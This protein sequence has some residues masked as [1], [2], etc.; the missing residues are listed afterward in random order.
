VVYHP[1]SLVIVQTME[2]HEC[3]ADLLHRLRKVRDVHQAQLEQRRQT[4]DR[5]YVAVYELAQGVP[6]A[7][8][9]A[10]LR[11]LIPELREEDREGPQPTYVEAFGRAILVCHA[12]G[13]HQRIAV[14]LPTLGVTPRVDPPGFDVPKTE[15][16]EG[17]V[18]VR[19]RCSMTSH[20]RSA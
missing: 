16:T 14:L 6:V 5:S 18:S 8:T 9:I 7:K 4:P 3:V 19:D 2:N 15:T 10:L 20:W 12:R 1:P 13:V 11:Q 17:L